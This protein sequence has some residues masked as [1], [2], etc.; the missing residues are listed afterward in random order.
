MG[1]RI[2]V[3]KEISPSQTRRYGLMGAYKDACKYFHNL[4]IGERDAAELNNTL[5]AKVASKDPRVMAAQRTS[6]IR[7]EWGDL[8][9]MAEQRGDL[10]GRE[11]KGLRPMLLV[12]IM[13][14]GTPKVHVANVKEYLNVTEEDLRARAAAPRNKR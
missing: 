3:T 9:V 2:R 10:P 12:E 4:T 5:E 8:K 1:D 14:N 6:C 11:G 7:P 13:P